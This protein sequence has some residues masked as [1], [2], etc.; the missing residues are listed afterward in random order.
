MIL[1][2]QD[3][4]PFF[5]SALIAVALIYVLGVCWFIAGMKRQEG[6]SQEQ[7]FASIVMAA[8]DEA[9]HL[10]ACLERLL[11]QD[12][13]EDRYEVIVVDDGSADGTAQ[14]A[15]K[16]AARD[17]RVRL[18]S[19]EAMLG[20]SG[21]KKAALSLGIGVAQG[22]IVLTTDA[23][24]LVPPSWVRGLVA[25]F[26]PETG[27]VVGFSQI[28]AP[29]QV[30]GARM[31]YEAVDF[32]CLMSCLLGSAGHDHPMAASGQNL[33]YRK[34]AFRQVGGYERVRHRASGDDVLLL[35][36]IRRFTRWHIAF[37]TDPQTYVIHSPSSS[38]GGFLRQRIR[39]ASNAP[40]Q[41][42]FDP[43][44]FFYMVATFAL[45]LLLILAPLLVLKGGLSAAAALGSGVAKILAEWRIFRQGSEFFERQ[46][47]QR[48]FPLWVLLQPLHV[49]VVGSLGC[50][51]VFPWKGRWHWWG[52]ARC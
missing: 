44:F 35:Q 36:M 5:D 42:L 26:G 45:N 22:E 17:H 52:R 48:F 7:P 24:C 38:W 30:R 14:I 2:L 4:R 19:T 46:E 20:Q 28:G 9:A 43:F 16:V 29:G 39:W 12:Y 25:Y 21:S 50:L 23:D 41:L 13:P 37:A 3:L 10:E 18:L 47:L 8:R 49:V 11:A 1:Q 6:K 34:E 27:L 32:L 40:L 51:G 33:A 15:G 31:G